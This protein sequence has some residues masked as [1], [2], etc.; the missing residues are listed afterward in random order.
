MDTAALETVGYSRFSDLVYSD[1]L[2]GWPMIQNG[3]IGDA[4]A[5]EV[6]VG[7]NLR[8]QITDNIISLYPY[9]DNFDTSR[10]ILYVS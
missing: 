1:G 6:A 10:N 2:G 8:Y 5:W 4:F 3:W 7:Q 9:L